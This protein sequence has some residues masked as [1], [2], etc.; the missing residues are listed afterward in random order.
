[1]YYSFLRVASVLCSV[2]MGAG[3]AQAENWYARLNGG[4][5]T[6]PSAETYL[7]SID[8]NLK[9]ETEIGFVVAGA[10]G[11]QA[12]ESFSVEGEMSYRRNGL[13]EVSYRVD[14]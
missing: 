4:I 6:G 11:W 5:G 1:M 13:D 9:T 8:G 12:T 7:S 2:L 10:I 3:I 14:V